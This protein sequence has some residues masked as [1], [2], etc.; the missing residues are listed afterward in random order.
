M[1]LNPKVEILEEAVNLKNLNN[2]KTGKGF[3]NLDSIQTMSKAKSI[4]GISP[5]MVAL[6][7]NISDRMNFSLSISNVVPLQIIISIFIQ[8]HLS[9]FNSKKISFCN[10]MIQYYL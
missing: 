5:M 9:D 3:G 7:N 6:L 4:K 10:S 1:E 2:V 8:R